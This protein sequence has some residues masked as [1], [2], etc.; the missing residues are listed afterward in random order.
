MKR[1]AVLYA[2]LDRSRNTREKV[3]ALSAYFRDAPAEDAAWAAWLLMGNRITRAV[4]RADLRAALATITGLP[5]WMIDECRDAVGDFSETIA[6]LTPP[7]VRGSGPSLAEAME[8]IVL[9]MRTMT[10]TARKAAL[11]EAWQRMPRDQRFVFQKLLGGAF[12]VGVSRTLAIRA[13]A[14]VAGVPQAT[15]THRVM[16]EW[17][18][19]AETFARLLSHATADVRVTQPYPFFLASSLESP[20]ESLGERSAWQAEWKWD[21]IRAQVI[22]R[23]G[24]TTVWSRGEES[25]GEQFTDLTSVLDG[26]ADGTV[27]D[28]EIVAWD[29]VHQRPLGFHALQRRL[30]RANQPRHDELLFVD[31]PVRFIAYDLLESN[32]QDRLAWPLE[33]RRGALE[34]VAE[35]LDPGG[36]A[37]RLSEVLDQPTWA[38][39]AAMRAGSR[40]RGVEGLMLKRR[41]SVY[42]SGRE[43]GDWWKWKIEPFTFDVVLTAAQT[44]SGR[45]ASVYTDYT[46]AVWSGTEPGTGDLVTIAKAYS[47]L[48]DDEIDRVDAFVRTATVSKHGPVRVVRPELVFELACEGIQDSSRH[49]A[50]LAVRFPRINR[51]RPDKRPVDADTVHSVR[52][53]GGLKAAPLQKRR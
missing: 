49:A 24:I 7:P 16:G 35:S 53:L 50:A 40:E 11:V 21:G 10:H 13:L 17:Q 4:S 23:G 18:P 45:R 26:L 48:T 8:G 33:Q 30:N 15:M 32:G 39:L 2:E 43:R 25:I 28:G 6:L 12:R 36:A 34:R 1:F 42:G 5:A 51:M 22:R 41:T 29:P 52:R 31:T 19:S 3:A 9:P 14:E 44:G 27:L 46:F 37:L 38:E 20:V 47:G